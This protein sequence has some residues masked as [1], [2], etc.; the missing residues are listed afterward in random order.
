MNNHR[1]NTIESIGIHKHNCITRAE[2][3]HE[4]QGYIIAHISDLSNESINKKT[5]DKRK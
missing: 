2:F 3:L 4:K 5:N 1:N